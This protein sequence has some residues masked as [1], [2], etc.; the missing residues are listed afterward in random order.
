MTTGKATRVAT[1]AWSRIFVALVVK[2][3]A[4]GGDG[5]NSSG[6]PAGGRRVFESKGPRNRRVGPAAALIST[7]L[8]ATLLSS[9]VG[10][11]TETPESFA[12]K[13]DV[14]AKSFADVAKLYDK[15]A[16][17]VF[18]E[19]GG[20]P[21]AAKNAL[22]ARDFFSTVRDQSLALVAPSGSGLQNAPAEMAQAAADYSDACDALLI[23]IDT[24]APSAIATAQR[25]RDS[26]H[27]RWV[28]VMKRV[29]KSVGKKPILP[30]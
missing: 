28:K 26:G 11:A 8:A 25:A 5:E 23:V 10:A 22:S 14:M 16:N 17:H 6:R 9:C 1:N 12:G 24:G 2:L 18:R 13:V 30:S 19:G 29:Y 7:L 15:N 3:A 21:V 4:Y 27:A 20:P